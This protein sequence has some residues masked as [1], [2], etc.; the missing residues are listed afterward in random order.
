MED[1]AAYAFGKR[2]P[3]PFSQDE[4]ESLTQEFVSYQIP[5]W[6]LI[7]GMMFGF[8]GLLAMLGIWLWRTERS[9]HFGWIGSV[10]AVVFGIAFIGIG[11]SYRYGI[12][13]SIA[14]VQLAQAM[15]GADDVRTQGMIAVY[16][17]PAAPR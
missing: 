14:S 8:L 6:T 11:L 17:P 15:D 2:D 5:P 3:K 7:I 16:R 10:L 1:L 9:E 13:D 12:P 4:L